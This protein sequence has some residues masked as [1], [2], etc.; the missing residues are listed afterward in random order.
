MQGGPAFHEVQ[1]Y[2]LTACLNPL[3]GL[4]IGT[5]DSGMMTVVLAV[6]LR[7]GFAARCLMPKVPKPRRYT[8][9]P[10]MTEPLIVSMMLSMTAATVSLSMPVDRD[11]SFV[12]SAFVMM[13]VF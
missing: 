1:I 8:G 2:L 3:H 12:R 10:C 5:S 11:T 4:N 6:M 7:A 13:S 9:S